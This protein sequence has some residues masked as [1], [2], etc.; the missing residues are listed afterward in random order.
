[1]LRG[2]KHKPGLLQVHLWSQRRDCFLLFSVNL[3]SL[4]LAVEGLSCVNWSQFCC[5]GFWGAVCSQFCNT[6]HEN[7]AFG[8]KMDKAVW[9]ICRAT[10]IPALVQLAQWVHEHR[11]VSETTK[12]LCE[13][14]VNCLGFIF[15]FYFCFSIDQ[16]A[17][18]GPLPSRFPPHIYWS[19]AKTKKPFGV[20]GHYLGWWCLSGSFNSSLAKKKRK[21]SSLK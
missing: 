7:N 19:E 21:L 15:P 16:A 10:L 3:C 8:L 2:T 11:E 4:Y 5:L 17:H 20:V 1:M 6:H 14:D 18:F 9:L 12:K 13:Y